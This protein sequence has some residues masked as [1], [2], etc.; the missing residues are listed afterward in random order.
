MSETENGSAERIKVGILG[1][2]NISTDLMYKLLNRPGHME[3]AMLAGI[4][5]ESDGLARARSEGVEASH[6][7]VEAIAADPEIEVVFDAT[8]AKAHAY[9]AEVLQE[10]GKTLVDLTPSHLGPF[11]VPPVN[12][13]E[14]PDKGDV[15]MISCG[16]QA[17]ISLIHAIGRVAPV[18]Y[19]ELITATASKSVGPG[20]RQ[21]IDEFTFTTADAMEAVGG[22]KKGRALP[23]INP[24]NPP[25]LMSNTVYAI[26]DEEFDEEAVVESIEGMVA[27]VQEY[28]PGYRLKARPTVE[29]RE[30]P[31]GNRPTFI[32]LNQVEGAG[33]YFPAYAGNHDIMTASAWRV[34]EIFAQRLLG[35]EEVAA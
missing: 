35:I 30:T 18:E 25:I 32:V 24:A 2:G 28:V 4:V 22:A 26:M 15:N 6:H 34:G 5:P 17:S 13:T 12:L 9:S 10:S 14:Y 29:R 23:I 16:G 8:S 31:W 33:D 19:A 27:E 1:S 7:G 11:V 3:V 21:N 20:T